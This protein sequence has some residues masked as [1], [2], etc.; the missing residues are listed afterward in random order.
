MVTN[1]LN[2]LSSENIKVTNCPSLPG[3]STKSLHPEKPLGP[4]RIRMVG[5]RRCLHFTCVPDGYFH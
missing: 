4:G 1:A 5:S 2:F 3:L